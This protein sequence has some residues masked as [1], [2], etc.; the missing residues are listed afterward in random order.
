MFQESVK[1]PVCNGTRL[2]EEGEAEP[3]HRFEVVAVIVRRFP[4]LQ[5]GRKLRAVGELRA[6]EE[7]GT[8]LVVQ[9][10]V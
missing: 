8:V 9:S 4:K 1:Q 7:L 3:E 10:R 6:P 2:E 5:V